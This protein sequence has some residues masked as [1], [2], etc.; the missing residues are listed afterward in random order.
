MSDALEGVPITYFFVFRE[1]FSEK[2]G[3]LSRQKINKQW[4][5][6]DLFRGF[7]VIFTSFTQINGWQKKHE[8]LYTTYFYT[9]DKIVTQY[10]NK[11]SI[12]M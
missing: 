9:P 4:S 12:R 1:N 11:S 5:T 6:Q 3:L 7:C 10:S 2:D 8:S